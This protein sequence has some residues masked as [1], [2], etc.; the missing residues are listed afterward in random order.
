MLLELEDGIEELSIEEEKCIL[1]KTD[2]NRWKECTRDSFK[3]W[4]HLS[5]EN[6]SVEEMY[7]SFLSL[8]EECMKECVPKKMCKI[9]ERKN[10]PHWRN[11]SVKEKKSV[12]NKAKKL[13]K[14]RGT[15]SNFQNLKA[16]DD[17]YQ[18]ACDLAKQEW[19]EDT[20]KKIEMNN[21]PRERW[22]EFKK[23]TTYQNEDVGGVLPLVDN[24]GTAIFDANKK[25][26]MLEETFFGGKHM[27]G[28][29]FDEGFKERINER[30]EQIK[31]DSTYKLGE[32]FLNKNITSEETEASIQRLQKSKAPGPDNIYSDLLK[33]ADPQLVEAITSLFQKSWIEGHVP[34]EWKF[35]K[36]KFLKKA[37]KKSYHSTNAYRPISL[38]STLGK[39]MERVVFSRLYSYVEHHSVIDPE[40]E[41]F[42][43]FHGTSMALLRLVQ[44]IVNGF[45]VGSPSV[46]VFIDMEKAYD[47]VWRNG[48]L[49]KLFDM[50]IQGVIWKWIQNFLCS[51]T[52]YCHLNGAE[53]SVFTTELGLPQG[54]VLSPLL[55]NLFIKDI[56][57]EVQSKKVKFADDGTI[58]RTGEKVEDLVVGIE[59]DLMK[60]VEWTYKWRMKLNIDKTEFCVFSRR[61]EQEIANVKVKMNGVDV[62]R[63]YFPKLL[64]VI[65]DPKLNFQ[66]HI[67]SV[68][69][70]ALTAA[71]ALVIV[72]KTDQISV[73]NMLKLYRSVVLPS[74]EYASTV[75]QIGNCDQLNRVQRKC[76]AVSLGLPSTSGLDAMEVEAGVLPLDLR[77]ED[78]AVREVTKIIAKDKRQKVAEC[79]DIW[80]N[81]VEGKPEKIVSPFGKAYMQ[82][83]DTVSNTGI[84][85]T[86]VEPEFSYMEHL[87]PTK[88]TPEYWNNLGSSKTRSTVQEEEAKQLIEGIITENGNNVVYA[89]TDGSCRGNPG[90]CGAGACIFLPSQEQIELKQPVSKRAS[91][92]LGELIAIKMALEFIN[93]EAKKRSL[94][95]AVLFSDSQSAVGILSLGWENKS[96]L[97]VIAE[98][99]ETLSNLLSQKIH[100]EL[101][102]TPGHANIQGNEV[103]DRLAKEAAQEAEGM[104]DVTKVITVGDIK[105]A[106]QESCY[107]KWQER[108]EA[109]STGRHLFELKPLVSQSSQHAK[110]IATQRII[111]QLRTGYGY[112]NEYQYKLGL[113][114]SPLCECG[115]IESVKHYLEDCAIFQD[116]RERLRVRMVKEIG[117]CEFSTKM[118][119]GVRKDKE[120]E[121]QTDQIITIL[122]DYVQETRRFKITSQ[123]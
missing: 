82:L 91:I 19:V 21:N 113:K 12:L 32:D 97:A 53:K 76:L 8:F 50:G 34:S 57:Q 36:V 54:S 66:K 119:L 68:E 39:C 55:F 22:Q 64:G 109:G 81:E 123:N 110:S 7:T 62:K 93:R 88:H 9:S 69:R 16:A 105:K 45:N 26:K 51:R 17:A 63:T 33:E 75:W 65:L 80:K 29:S 103:A 40:Q 47:S 121:Y 122:E 18:Q 13:F 117:I 99:K 38:T 100:V 23:L 120:E 31:T 27:V 104:P 87:Q 72:G 14:R 10:K 89:F 24:D 61:S 43:K 71:A 92:L 59:S 52:A 11:E 30:V 114:D 41:G 46:A 42:R 49:V 86:K 58:W 25:C 95:E 70:K 56:Y 98:I 60:I 74:M 77:R 102:W 6:E 94:E 115:E 118:F 5:H 116:V 3:E 78:L 20:C 106:V 44:D 83:M 112:L 111:S 2:W 35:A 90:P 48:L 67:E 73:K 84:D 79:F 4:N 15:P 85:I 108:W 1:K 101:K 96:H 28:Q 107:F 37:G